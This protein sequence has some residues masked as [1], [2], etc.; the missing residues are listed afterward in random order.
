MYKQI[1]K[2]LF[3]ETQ[4]NVER[5]ATTWEKFQEAKPKNNNSKI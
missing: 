2:Y 4:L 5:N 3:N 1:M